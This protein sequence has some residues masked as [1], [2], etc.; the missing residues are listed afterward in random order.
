MSP[1]PSPESNGAS[2]PDSHIPRSFEDVTMQPV[3]ENNTYFA[4]GVNATFHS[5]TPFIQRRIQRQIQSHQERRA[6]ERAEN[7]ELVEPRSVLAT[8]TSNNL[9]DSSAPLGS[10]RQLQLQFQDATMDHEVDISSP[11]GAADMQLPTIEEVV[12]AVSNTQLN[13]RRTVHP[14]RPFRRMAPNSL[15]SQVRY[16]A[17]RERR[18]RRNAN[19]TGLDHPVPII[20]SSLAG[21]P[22]ADD[23]DEAVN[24]DPPLPDNMDPPLPNPAVNLYTPLPDAA[25]NLD[26]FTA[27]RNIRRCSTLFDIGSVGDGDMEYENQVIANCMELNSIQGSIMRPGDMH[28]QARGQE[29][30]RHQRRASPHYTFTTPTNAHSSSVASTSASAPASNNTTEAQNPSQ[31]SGTGTGT[32]NTTDLEGMSEE[33]VD[34][35]PIAKLSI[36]GPSE[37]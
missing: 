26:N 5:L 16:I 20:S 6:I 28:T 35:I 33:G 31:A 25:M 19:D 9:P 4:D 23:G 15:R 34:D 1:P 8:A 36:G 13:P 18:R 3:P 2:S 11:S 14:T 21:T 29:N 24:M 30:T 12:H 17:R 32:G 10:L 37:G 27:R 22:Y 7:P